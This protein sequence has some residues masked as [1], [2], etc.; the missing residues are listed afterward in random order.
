M[1]PQI[2][3]L[4]VGGRRFATT[5][6]TLQRI[7][8]SYLDKLV[9]GQVPIIKDK[10]G[11]I[12]LDKNST[13]FEYILDYLR[14]GELIYPDDS[15]LKNQM[16]KDVQQMRLVQNKGKTQWTWDA[17]QKS[18]TMTLLNNNLSAKAT[19]STSVVFGTQQFDSGIWEWEITFDKL[20]SS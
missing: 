18:S 19:S 11:Y 2:I 3:Y 1:N 12:F 7:P 15:K 13:V 16:K 17:S 5:A 14:D 8:D 6:K 9:K 20:L 4:N 10:D